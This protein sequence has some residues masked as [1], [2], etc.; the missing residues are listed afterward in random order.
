M[1]TE[2][3][4]KLSVGEFARQMRGQLIPLGSHFAYFFA[5]VPA[6][7]DDVKEYLADPIM[8]LPPELRAVLPHTS[9]LF[10]PYLERGAASGSGDSPVEDL[11][12]FERPKEEQRIQASRIQ[13][14]E[15]A[16]LA[17]SLGGDDVAE[18]HYRLFHSL[19][20]LTADV[21]EETVQE[22]FAAI[23]RDEL[24]AGVHGEVDESSWE[25]KRELIRRQRDLRR[26][27]KGFAKYARQA[28]IDTLTLYLH[29]ICCDIDVE[30][31]PRQIAS[32]HL[33]RRLEFFN[34]LFPPPEGYAV[35]P[36]DVNHANE[37]KA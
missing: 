3:P 24:S 17:F 31:G 12:C 2:N 4:E 36:E 25:L 8:A 5:G 13:T 15:G 19:A 34:S 21:A 37:K 7:A 35:F 32:R 14:D 9:I 29:G 30:T 1:Q 26:K 16:V 23:V 22:Q 33:R 6:G 10:V 28:L 27:T 20:R 18:Y 11:I